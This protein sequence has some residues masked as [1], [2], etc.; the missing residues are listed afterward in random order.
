MMAAGSQQPLKQPP[1]M[2]DRCP[3]EIDA[4]TPGPASD[5]DLDLPSLSDEHLPLDVKGPPMRGIRAPVVRRRRDWRRSAR[6]PRGP[7][8]GGCAGGRLDIRL[9]LGR[10]GLRRAR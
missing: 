8:E 7:R 6:P 1:E 3:S 10:R 9:A 2:T 4:G 5:G